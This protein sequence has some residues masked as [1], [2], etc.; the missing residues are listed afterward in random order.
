M[1]RN[2]LDNLTAVI[3]KTQ[4]IAQNCYCWELRGNQVDDLIYPVSRGSHNTLPCLVFVD[5]KN[6]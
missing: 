6:Q 4:F 3:L 5:F 2:C 1:K